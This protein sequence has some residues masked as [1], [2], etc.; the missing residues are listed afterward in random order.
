MQ[1]SDAAAMG[2]ERCPGK[3]QNVAVLLKCPFE[4]DWKARGFGLRAPL[5][6]FR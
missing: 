5:A 2:N 3:L 4:T 6:A 1:P